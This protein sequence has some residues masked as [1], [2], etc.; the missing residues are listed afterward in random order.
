MGKTIT[1]CGQSGCGQLTK[2]VNQILVS[3]T[4]PGRLRGAGVRHQGNG[5]DPQKTIEAV[6]GGAAKLVAAENLGPRM[7]AGDFRPGFM[8][9][10]S[11]RTCA[12]SCMR[13]EQIGTSVPGTSLVAPALDTPPKPPATA[14]MARRRS[15]PSSKSS[16]ICTE[17]PRQRRAGQ[18][19]RQ[20]A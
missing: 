12:W 14:A 9:D 13:R 5:L 1:Y 16:R 15:I 6:G 7:V 19:A 11:R 3:I 17:S 2:L 20:S 8:I 4:Q 10:L 18:K